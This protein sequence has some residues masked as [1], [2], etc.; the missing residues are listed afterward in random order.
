MIYRQCRTIIRTTVSGI[1]PDPFAC[2]EKSGP[3]AKQGDFIPVILPDGA[4]ET[5]RIGRGRTIS[6][7]FPAPPLISPDTL[8]YYE[9][10][11]ADVLIPVAFPV[12]CPV[13]NVPTACMN[14]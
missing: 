14:R 13:A 4:V 2:P 6:R 7:H 12:A 10:M 3:Y 9:I 5:S 1:A 8:M 11:N